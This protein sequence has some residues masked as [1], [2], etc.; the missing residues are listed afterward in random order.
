MVKKREQQELKQENL[1][2]KFHENVMKGLK[3]MEVRVSVA[4]NG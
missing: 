4:R 1:L 2:N 3:G